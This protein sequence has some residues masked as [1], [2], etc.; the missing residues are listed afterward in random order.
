[1]LEF[2]TIIGTAAGDIGAVD[3]QGVF[4]F[5]HGILDD[6]EIAY[7]RIAAPLRSAA[8]FEVS[9]PEN[10]GVERRSSEE[11][12]DGECGGPGSDSRGH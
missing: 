8:G 4:A 3:A 9:A 1:M 7:L 12:R 5:T 11:E 10:F 2:D 6:F